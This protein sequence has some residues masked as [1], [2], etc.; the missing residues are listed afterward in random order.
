MSKDPVLSLGSLDWADSRPNNTT[1]HTT[2]L[3]YGTT[4]GG[5]VTIPVDPS[6]TPTWPKE[7]WST[8]TTEIPTG[9]WTPATTTATPTATTGWGYG[10][11]LVPTVSVPRSS[12]LRRYLTKQERRLVLEA[13]CDQ[14]IAAG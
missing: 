10:G 2:S 11:G 3:T 5:T 1:Y 12:R 9:W 6:A 14:L 7:W 8:S 4:D 13:I